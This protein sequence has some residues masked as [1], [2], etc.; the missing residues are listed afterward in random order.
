[1][2]STPDAVASTSIVIPCFNQG[3]FL[4]RAIDSAFAQV[5]V[6]VEIIVVD[7]GSTDE[8]PAVI[9]EHPEVRAIR[10]PNRGV[11]AARNAGLGAARRDFIVFLDADDELFPDAVAAGV[12]ALHRYPDASVAAGRVA[13]V[14]TEGLE[15]PAIWPS[16]RPDGRAR[17]EDLLATNIIWTPRA[18]IFRRAPL[19]CAGGFDERWSHAADY[20]LYLHFAR[21]GA[22]V[23]HGR[24]VARYRQHP[25]AMS[26]DAGRMLRET[27]C[28]LRSEW[29]HVGVDAQHAWRRGIRT[30]REW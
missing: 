5:D 9:A 4:G 29:P 20:A 14:D 25:D 6:A 1:M 17:Y 11:A 18:A 24:M 12:D 28:V 2:S 3:R 7:D 22:I 16:L 8:T 19:V 13:P 26:C 21:A 27:L 15:L 10:Q 23:W 30:W